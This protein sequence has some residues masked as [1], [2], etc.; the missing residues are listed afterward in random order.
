[1]KKTM[2]TYNTLSSFEKEYETAQYT[3]AEIKEIEFSAYVANMNKCNN[4]EWTEIDVFNNFI[5]ILE[6]QR[7]KTELKNNC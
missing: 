4:P 3:K 7:I 2:L 6:I 5:Q 1:M